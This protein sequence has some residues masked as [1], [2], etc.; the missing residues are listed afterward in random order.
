MQ[1]AWFFAVDTGSVCST[2][3]E[4][5]TQDSAGKRVNLW[6]SKV[7]GKEKWGLPEQRRGIAGRSQKTGKSGAGEREVKA[8]AGP[9][10]GTAA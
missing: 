2:E 4:V 8:E 10:L 6:V 3:D 9:K 1:S 7:W 5:L